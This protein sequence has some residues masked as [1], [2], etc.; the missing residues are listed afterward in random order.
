[1]P[2]VV[3]IR[4]GEPYDVFVGRPSKFGNPFSHQPGT[5]ALYKVETREE[6]VEYYRNYLLNTP[7]LLQMVKQELKGK[8]L[9]CFCES[10][11]ACHAKVLLEI[12]N[13]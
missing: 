10:H 6:A 13:S 3:N 12:A 7:A 11:L 8:N 5:L 9:G 1:M 4:S 2:K